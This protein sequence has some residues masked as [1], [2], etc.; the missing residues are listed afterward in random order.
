MAGVNPLRQPFP[1]TVEIAPEQALWAGSTYNAPYYDISEDR[2]ATTN[3]ELQYGR[4][5]EAADVEAASGAATFDNRD[6][7]LS[8]YNPTG[9]WYG[10]LDANVPARMRMPDVWNDDFQRST[11]NSWGVT[12]D[13]YEWLPAGSR[14][15]TAAGV[16][17]VTF[18]SANLANW[19]TLTGAGSPDMEVRAAF[20]ASV[21]PTG[22]DLVCA[23]SFHR[24]SDD[25]TTLLYLRFKT[26]G[27]LRWQLRTSVAG[28][29]TTVAFIDTLTP[30][31]AGQTVHTRIQFEGPLVRARAW[32]GDRVADEPQFFDFQ[33]ETETEAPDGTGI[34]LLMW[35]LVGETTV[36]SV[37]L[38]CYYFESD[39]IL[40]SGAGYDLPPSWDK[41]GNDSTTVVTFAGALRELQARTEQEPL[42]SA[43]YRKLQA[44]IDDFSIG[45]VVFT[46]C[47]DGSDSTYATSAI[48]DGKPSRNTGVVFGDTDGIP[49]GIEACAKYDSD[50]ATFYV[51]G[52]ESS[53]QEFAAMILLQLPGNVTT[54]TMLYEW[55]SDQGTVRLWQV[56]LTSGNQFFVRGIGAGGV[57][58]FTS[59]SFNVVIT[60]T[61]WFAMQLEV[62]E[63]AGT[64]GWTLLWTEIGVNVFWYINGTFAGTLAGCR[65]LKMS[66][67]AELNGMR[68]CMIWIGSEHLPFVTPG[69]TEI[70][71]GYPGE[72]DTE[73]IDRLCEEEGVPLVLQPGAGVPLGRQ[74]PGT[75][76]SLL[77]E[78][79]KAGDGLLTERG[80]GLGYAPHRA[81]ENPGLN[82]EPIMTLDWTGG[83]LAEAP[84]P[85]GD[86]QRYFSRYTA[87][88]VDGGEATYEAAESVVNRRGLVKAGDDLNLSTDAQLPQQAAWR[89]NQGAWD[90]LRWPTIVIDL[91]AHPELI[92]QWLRCKVGSRIRVIN[93]KSQVLGNEIDLII[94]GVQQVV[95]L[96]VWKV[97]LACSPAKMWD[98]AVYG[99]SKRLLSS[100]STT[101]FEYVDE[102]ETSIEVSFDER[103]HAWSQTGV[104]YPWLVGGEEMTVTAMS[105]VSGTG[106]FYQTATVTRSVN[107]VVKDHVMFTPVQVHRRVQARYA[108]PA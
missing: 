55:R 14:L 44:Y 19:I 11:S 18:P 60:K 47:E 68:F 40:F 77:R 51:K 31:T 37:S 42:R 97:T 99:S 73:R 34:G 32:T 36:G 95:G 24:E 46:P 61:N 90:E 41:S 7:D 50:T 23:L 45:G 17:T 21:I 38:R 48:V 43:M 98:V 35:R 39:A 58:V 87:R 54:N 93:P 91:M 53:T 8:P 103:S 56:W 81:R 92:D 69:F 79:A 85:S 75:L 9:R 3:I 94:E 74:K 49:G 5:D 76:L 13:G 89:V 66:A 102:T 29:L 65:A 6:G 83:Q 52:N 33:W 59:A 20:S 100:R 12:A 82:T 63:D 67:T 86:D 96:Y 64:V 101:L 25:D 15:S 106:P 27:T 22:A 105:A 30:Y 2:R 88:R 108:L 84:A 28:V 57:S 107:G 62:V 4:A 10:Q 80:R 70:A 104:P 78:S 16:A 71:E 26:D 72:L 1:V